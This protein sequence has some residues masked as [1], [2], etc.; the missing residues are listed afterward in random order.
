MAKPPAPGPGRPATEVRPGEKGIESREVTTQLPDDSM[1]LLEAIGRALDSPT[2][3]VMVDALNAY[4]VV[5]SSSM[6]PSPRG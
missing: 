4:V 6:T 1:M 3:R 2:P 5:W